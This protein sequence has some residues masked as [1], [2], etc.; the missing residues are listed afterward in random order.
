MNKLKEHLLRYKEYYLGV[1]TAIGALLGAIF[2]SSCGSTVRATIRTKDTP[3]GHS[4][5]I[6]TNNPSE[7]TVS[8]TTTVKFNSKNQ[9][10]DTK[11]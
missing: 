4:I 9:S 3:A 5:S 7:V 8:P 10:Y 1:I 6:N 2:F 11:Y